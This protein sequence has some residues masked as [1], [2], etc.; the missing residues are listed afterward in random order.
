MAHVPQD[1]YL[2]RGLRL[3][4]REGVGAI[5]RVKGLKALARRGAVEPKV[6]CRYLQALLE[7]HAW[8]GNSRQAVIDRIATEDRLR[9]TLQTSPH[10]R[11][12]SRLFFQYLSGNLEVGEHTELHLYALVEMPTLQQFA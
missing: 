11:G 3:L 8:M 1:E 2:P 12:A 6:G 4:A 9:S 5:C 7:L 10:L